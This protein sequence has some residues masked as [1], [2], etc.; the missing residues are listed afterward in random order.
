MKKN[1]SAK[2]KIKNVSTNKIVDKNQYVD[3]F[4]THMPQI[5]LLQK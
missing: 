4:K 5:H 2:N 3:Y 1:N